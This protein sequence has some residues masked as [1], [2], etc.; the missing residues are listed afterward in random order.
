[1]PCQLTQFLICADE[2]ATLHAFHCLDLGECAEEA[3]SHSLDGVTDGIKVVDQGS[4]SH[5]RGSVGMGEGDRIALQRKGKWMDQCPACCR[6]RLVIVGAIE[7]I[8]LAGRTEA[9]SP[10]ARVYLQHVATDDSVRGAPL[11][12]GQRDGR[13]IAGGAKMGADSA[14]LGA[15]LLQL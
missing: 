7:E 12:N 9:L 14:A 1:E 13:D 2:E 11:A 8:A 6:Q 10:V 3:S 5:Q 4:A 15:K